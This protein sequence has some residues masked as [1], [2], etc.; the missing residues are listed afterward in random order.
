[1]KAR[2]VNLEIKKYG[3]FINKENAFLHATPNFL[4]SC[5]CCG[6]GCGEVKCPIVIIDGNFDDYVE[7]NHSCLEKV[8]G[9]LQLKKNHSYY[10]QVQQQLFSVQIFSMVRML[11]VFV[12]QKEMKTKFC[13]VTRTAL[14]RGFTHHV[15]LL[16]PWHCQRPGTVLTVADVLSSRG[17]GIPENPHDLPSCQILQL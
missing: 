9:N 11:F 13:V 17:K 10:Y 2:H 4:V 6:S 7:H 3:L 16:P 5:D 12:E 8:N 1:M 14:I 15:P